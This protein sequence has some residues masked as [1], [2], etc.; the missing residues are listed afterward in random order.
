LKHIRVASADCFEARRKG[1]NG[2]YTDYNPFPPHLVKRVTSVGPR[3]LFQFVFGG[4]AM[5]DL[6][7]DFHKAIITQKI[8]SPLSVDEVFF[9]IGVNTIR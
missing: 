6:V 4:W 5:E 2:S 3:N 9:V 1:V 8:G 7:P